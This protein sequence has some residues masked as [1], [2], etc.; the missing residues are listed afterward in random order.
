MEVQ[1]FVMVELEFARFGDQHSENSGL[2]RV[3]G[4]LM[5]ALSIVDLHSDVRDIQV[6][7]FWLAYC[8]Y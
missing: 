2:Q 3:Q 6:D 7:L 1:C 4:S 5:L 8:T